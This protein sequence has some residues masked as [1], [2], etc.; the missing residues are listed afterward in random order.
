MKSGEFVIV[1][2]YNKQTSFPE[3]N[4]SRINYE[5]QITNYG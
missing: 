5:F 3:I 2:I 4:L 1:G